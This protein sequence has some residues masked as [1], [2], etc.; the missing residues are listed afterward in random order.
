MAIL[1]AGLEM[2]LSCSH[3]I[4]AEPMDGGGQMEMEDSSFDCWY[5]LEPLG[6]RHILSNLVEF[7]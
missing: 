2:G 4:L 7:E 6:F 1:Q 3:I 5:G